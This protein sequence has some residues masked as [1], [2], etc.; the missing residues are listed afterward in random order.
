[1][2]PACRQLVF[3]VYSLSAAFMIDNPMKGSEKPAQSAI[4]C[5]ILSVGQ[6]D[7]WIAHAR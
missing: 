1:M 5:R 2:L 3:I 7:R 4:A 6:T